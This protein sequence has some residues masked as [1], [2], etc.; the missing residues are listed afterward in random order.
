VRNEWAPF[1]KFWVPGVVSILLSTLFWVLSQTDA[2][3]CFKTHAFQF[4]GIWHMGAGA[5]ALLLYFFWRS[6]RR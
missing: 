6:A 1:W 2:P 5:T 4:H 3:L